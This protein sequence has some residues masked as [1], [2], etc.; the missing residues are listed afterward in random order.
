MPRPRTG[1]CGPWSAEDF[2]AALRMIYEAGLTPAL[3]EDYISL[4]GTVPDPAAPPSA[5][6][7]A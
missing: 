1:P 4:P 7:A 6:K 3:L 2:L 5:T